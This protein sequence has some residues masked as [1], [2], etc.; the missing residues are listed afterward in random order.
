MPKLLSFFDTNAFDINVYLLASS[1]SDASLA[2]ASEEQRAWLGRDCGIT[3]TYDGP[4]IFIK[5]DM[6]INKVRACIVSLMIKSLGFIETETI[7]DLPGSNLDMTPSYPYLTNLDRLL[8]RVLYDRRYAP[9]MPQAEGMAAA[10]RIVAE[11]LPR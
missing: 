2:N 6:S 11:L 10:K 7:A 4:L 3:A 5:Y 8:V 1:E 9:S